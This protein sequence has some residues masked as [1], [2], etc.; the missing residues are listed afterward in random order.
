MMLLSFMRGLL[1]HFDNIEGLY[2]VMRCSAVCGMSTPAQ[3]FKECAFHISIGQWMVALLIGIANHI[4]IRHLWPKNLLL[5]FKKLGQIIKQ[6]QQNI[7][8]KPL[9]FHYR[10]GSI[11]TLYKT[12]KKKITRRG[13]EITFIAGDQTVSQGC[14]KTDLQHMS[15]SLCVGSEYKNYVTESN[16]F[17]SKVHLEITI[18]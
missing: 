12:S 1:N 5:V 10:S 6:S 3:L 9:L 7:T 2:K 17:L 15:R 18:L 8:I 13:H 16:A 4:P 11:R 14:T